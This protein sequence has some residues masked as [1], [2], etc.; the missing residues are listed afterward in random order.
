MH[1]TLSRE[2]ASAPPALKLANSF[3]VLN[4]TGP[5]AERYLHGRLTQDVKGLAVHS[6][7]QSL[8]LTPQGK[9]IGQTFILREAEDAFTLLCD[10]IDDTSFEAFIAGLLQFKVADR[11]ECTPNAALQNTIIHLQPDSFTPSFTDTKPAVNSFSTDDASQVIT[12][13]HSG[14]RASFIVVCYGSNAAKE[15][16]GSFPEL[17]TSEDLFTLFRVAHLFPLYGQELNEKI[18]AT[19]I[20]VSNLV[21]FTKG[22]YTGQETVEMSIARGKPNKKLVAIEAPA[23]SAISAGDDILL[24]DGSRAGTISTVLSPEILQDR[25]SHFALGFI[26]TSLKEDASLQINNTAVSV[27]D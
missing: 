5:D 22:C 14:K 27:L 15:V 25:S 3:K 4:I 19:D 12:L 9:I 1:P 2:L 17:I 20:D 10:P 16:E 6:S 13:H 26:K 11:L 21:S 8:L 18:T 7:A 23:E 24:A